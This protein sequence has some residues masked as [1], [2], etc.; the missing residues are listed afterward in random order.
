MPRYLVSWFASALRA[1]FDAHRRRTPRAFF[2]RVSLEST[3]VTVAVGFLLFA[4]YDDSSSTDVEEVAR[5]HPVLLLIATCIVAPLAETLL[6]SLPVMVAR[7][8]GAAFWPQVFIAV[9]PFAALHFRAGVGA[10]I[11]AGVVGGFYLAFSY[12]HW[13]EISLGRAYWMTCAAHALSNLVWV[14]MGLV[15]LALEGPTPAG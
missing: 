7:R 3:L 9:I 6:Q 12:A 11:C 5:K 15:G 10:G 13:R 4:L 1:H 8:F 14:T 2:W